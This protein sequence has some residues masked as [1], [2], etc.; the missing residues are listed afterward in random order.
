MFQYTLVEPTS[1]PATDALVARFLERGKKLG[2]AGTKLSP[3]WRWV[4]HTL[5]PDVLEAYGSF[6]LVGTDLVPVELIRGS[7]S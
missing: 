5:G 6:E 4:L 2:Q 1:T 7:R 3:Y